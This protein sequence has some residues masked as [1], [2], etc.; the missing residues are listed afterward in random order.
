ME[1]Y[2]PGFLLQPFDRALR[3]VD[4]RPISAPAGPRPRGATRV[5]N[6]PRLKPGDPR[7]NGANPDKGAA[8]PLTPLPTVK[9][10]F[11]AINGRPRGREGAHGRK[12]S[13]VQEGERRGYDAFALR[14][15]RLGGSRV[16]SGRNCGN[17][18]DNCT[19]FPNAWHE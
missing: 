14:D 10:W 1:L 2:P 11:T 12:G 8:D 5:R 17:G 7:P 4:V 3:S 6:R 9:R 13:R 18:N 15:R 16:S 19:A